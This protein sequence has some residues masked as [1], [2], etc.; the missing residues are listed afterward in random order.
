MKLL[1]R[2]LFLADLMLTLVMQPLQDAPEDQ[3][4]DVL[5]PLRE[6]LNEH[7]VAEMLEKMELD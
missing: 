4:P 6:I 2:L 3:V 7:D 5:R 1:L